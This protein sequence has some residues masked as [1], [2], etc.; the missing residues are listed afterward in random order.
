MNRLLKL[1]LWLSVVTIIYNFAEG[2]VSVF[3]GAKDSALT[4]LGFGI[5]SFV[6][7][8]SGLGIL[9]M[10]LR[11]KD[12]TIEKTDKFEKTALQIT[13]YGFYILTLGLIAASIINL[14]NEQKPQTTL[15][16]IFISIISIA[17]M[18]RL[19]KSKLNV[20]RKLNSNA[21]IADANCTKT[22]FYLSIIL[23]ASSLLYE[24]FRIGFIDGAGS[25]GIAYYSFM[26]GKESLE[27]AKKDSLVCNDDVCKTDEKY[28]ELHEVSD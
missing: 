1:A 11:M 27:K 8:I 4:L 20:G 16:G 19:M 24:F 28:S 10:V 17:V 2:L 23:L 7:I 15:I 25:L 22:C 6:E 26:E 12:S 9:H 5:D 3:F 13:G 14:I 18:Y 21:I